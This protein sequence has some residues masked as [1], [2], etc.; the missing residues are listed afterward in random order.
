MV[1]I[2]RTREPSDT[3][4]YIDANTNFLRD[5]RGLI[6]QDIEA[7]V[8]Q[9]YNILATDIGERIFEP[10][11]GSDLKR[12]LFSPTDETT[13][14]LIEGEVTRAL[15]RWMPRIEIIRNQTFATPYPDERYFEILIRYR[16]V[17]TGIFDT[18]SFNFSQGSSGF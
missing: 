4:Y 1:H 6:V 5:E 9:V 15:G 18:L 17:N 3:I 16:I 13:G 12:Y 7:I 14:W 11:F 2:T 8:N 10:E